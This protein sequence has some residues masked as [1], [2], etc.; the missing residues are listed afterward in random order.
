MQNF[1]EA[2]ADTISNPK[3]KFF[4]LRIVNL[5]DSQDMT[6]FVPKS[7]S[8]HSLTGSLFVFY[9]LCVMIIGVL[10]P[11]PKNLIYGVPWT[12]CAIWGGWCIIVIAGLMDVT[13]T[14]TLSHFAI[15]I[16]L[17]GVCV[18]SNYIFYIDSELNLNHLAVQFP[19][20]LIT[21][22]TAFILMTGVPA[23]RFFIL[24]DRFT[25]IMCV[26]LLL[27]RVSGMDFSR[28]GS[29]LGLGPLTF[30]K[31]VSL[32]LLSRLLYI[33]KWPLS[34]IFLYGF[35]FFIADSKGPTLYVIVSLIV[36][37]VYHVKLS[38][39]ILALPLLL[40]LLFA[41]S[42]MPR[43]DAFIQEIAILP[44]SL[45]NLTVSNL[46]VDEELVS[47]TLA[48]AFAA[49][50]TVAI[51]IQNPI[52][53]VGPGEWPKM[54]GMESLKYPHNSVL[55]IWSEY[56]LLAVIILFGIMYRVTREIRINNPY[57]IFALFSFLTTLSS[58]SIKDL[59]ML[60]VFGLITFYYAA[61]SSKS[62]K[63]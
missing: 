1:L 24:L 60:A 14:T 35:A 40:L 54:T 20:L 11:E 28:E 18:L 31:Y 27:V 21:S 37:G 39:R 45:T 12:W 44:S 30:I 41:V 58:G 33:R 23:D 9:G 61:K 6:P 56:G 16:T 59:R 17:V 19:T 13:K 50:E 55:E 29:F 8:F 5:Q 46:D 57:A 25:I 49:K 52:L 2:L 38:R 34:V 51:I 10:Y 26:A 62:L 48:R 4:N 63:V 7:I 42:L 32:G 47:G 3:P 53:G 15:F 43:M 22:S 36:W